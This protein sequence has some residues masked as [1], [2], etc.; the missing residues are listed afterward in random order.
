MFKV[1][2]N[3]SPKG[4]QPKAIESIVNA[5][6][7][8]QQHH[9]LLGV[10]GSGK[11]FTMAN[12]ISKLQVPTLIIAPNKTLAAQLY[13]EFKEYFPEENVGY[14][15]SYY[16]YYQ[17]EAYIPASDTYIEKDSAI[18]EDIDKMR[19]EATRF[20]FEKRNTIIVASVSCIYGLGSPEAYAEQ[21]IHLE[22]DTDLER[23]KLLRSLIEMQY[24]RNDLEL[25]RGKFRV[26]GE[27]VDILPAHQRDEAVRIS[28]FGD[29]IEEISLI[30]ALSGRILK[31]LEKV[32]IYPGS[33]YIAGK[34]AIH[35]IVQSILAD[36]G[37]RLRQLKSLQ[38]FAEA[39]RL[40]ERTMADIESFEQLG[41][42][43][44]VENYSRYLTGLLPGEPPPCL[45][46]YFPKDFLTIIDESHITVPQIG[47]MYSG[48]RSRK[49][50]LVEYGF[51]LPAALDNRPLNFPEFLSRNHQILYV[52]ATPS[53][54]EL[55]LAQG[56]IS[57]QIIRPTGLLDPVI[58]V[59]SAHM[60]VDHL[61]T[62][63][64]QIIAGGKRV[65][66]TTLTKK[67]AEDLCAHYTESGFRVEYLHSE[68][69]A[70]TRADLLRD[71]RLGKYD[72]LIGINLLREGIDIPEVSLVAI[73]DADKE[74]FLRSR[75]SLIQIIGR[76]ARNHQ[77]RVILYADKIT[78]SMQQAI[79]ET[80]RRRSIQ[81]QFNQE[82]NISPKTI[83][84]PVQQDLRVIYGLLKPLHEGAESATESESLHKKLENWDVKKAADLEKRIRSFSKKMQ[85]S[86]SQLDFENAA[87]LRDEVS[88]MKSV[89]ALLIDQEM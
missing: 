48:D 81:S 4:D 59:V 41:F 7:S 71:L 21:V 44:G 89:L 78:N 10:T 46:D 37:V 1:Q 29:S 5:F 79:D 83:L 72:V 34:S 63:M 74:G 28:F 86:A 43:P 24:S 85:K 60:Q 57:E 73:M 3:Y 77:G 17:P 42:C 16:D 87:S 2:S 51:R 54:R 49:T 58:E 8:G 80:N 25:T 62:Q 20:L 75:A 38:K 9:V 18:N 12:V 82:N 76:A 64:Q 11:T 32:S 23:D 52:S 19:H 56:S 53:Y 40:E 15:I 33:H 61:Q 67:M 36:L 50:N 30:D 6:S 45:L 35:G 55:D 68:I 70:L 14:F 27:Q 69:D 66:I 22:V 65:L 31:T 88:E 26:R 13:L 39:T 47:G 84:K